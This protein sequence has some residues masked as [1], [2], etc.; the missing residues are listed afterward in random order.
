M[1]TREASFLALPVV[2]RAV[3]GQKT[4]VNKPRSP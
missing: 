1:S 4:V 3:A 2:P